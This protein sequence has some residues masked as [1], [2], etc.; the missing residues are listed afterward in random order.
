[1]K[2]DMP[3]SSRAS[4]MTMNIPNKKT[5]KRCISTKLES[6]RIDPQQTT[7]TAEREKEEERLSYGAHSM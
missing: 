7:C 1:M 6:R 2:L 4:E 3:T 5:K